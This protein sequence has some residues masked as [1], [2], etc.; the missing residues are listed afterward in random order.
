MP[1]SRS[2]VRGSASASAAGAGQVSADTTGGRSLSRCRTSGVTT[3]TAT[4]PHA[5]RRRAGVRC[6]SHEQRGAAYPAGRLARTR[7]PARAGETRS[8]MTLLRFP[9]LR[10]V[11][12]GS[13]LAARAARPGAGGGTPHRRRRH[14][15]AARPARSWQRRRPAP[16]PAP[17]EVAARTSD[18]SATPPVARPRRPRPMLGA[19]TRER[20]TGARR[21]AIP[22]RAGAGPLRRSPAAR[23]RPAASDGR[24]RASVHRPRAGAVAGA[25][26]CLLARRRRAAAAPP[27]AA[28]R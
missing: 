17:G 18:I 11:R 6:G 20:P 23:T 27:P 2:G 19:P 21:P 24:R 14:A 26:L 28:L 9:L 13:V 8:A 25:G 7:R 16:Q 5:S 4:A 10:P 12:A 15:R 3:P 1:A 22:R